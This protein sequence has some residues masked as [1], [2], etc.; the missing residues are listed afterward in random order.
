MRYHG[1]L[2]VEAGSVEDDPS[3]LVVQLAHGTITEIFILFPPGPAGLVYFQIWHQARQ[4]CPLTPGTAFQ[5]DDTQINYTERYK[6]TGVPYWVELRGWAPDAELD[7]T[8]QASFTVLPLARV[9][10]IEGAFIPLP[11]GFL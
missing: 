3:T 11:E 10:V 5:G 9:G 6:I 4:I 1:A 7:H 8:I 2:L